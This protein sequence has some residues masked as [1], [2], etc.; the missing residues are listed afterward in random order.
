[1]GFRI[2]SLNTG[3]GRVHDRLMEYLGSCGANLLCLQEMV[4]T[5]A[6]SGDWLTYRGHGPDLPQR[7]NLHREI[8]E[9]LPAHRAWFAP[10]ARGPLHDG[11]DVVLSEFGLSTLLNKEH[12]VLDEATGFIHGAFSPDGWGEHPRPRNAHVLRLRRADTGDALTVCHFHGL[13]DESGKGDTPAR[14]AQAHALAAM[15]RRVWKEGEPLVVCGDF[16]VLP[17]SATFPIL[18]E[19]GLVDL[20]TTSGFTDT[21]TSLYAKPGRYADYMMVTPEVGVADFTVVV[22]PEV[23]DHRALVLDVA[24]GVDQ[25]RLNRMGR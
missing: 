16:N 20:V 10:A 2:L 6:A 18:G 22:E 25:G 15:I 21:R 19:L 1:M 17:G 4:Q 13:R 24:R 12:T 5:R 9:L 8:A 14:V 3:G 7:A 11:D 23:S